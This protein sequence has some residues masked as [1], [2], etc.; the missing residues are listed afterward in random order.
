[1]PVR[2][3]LLVS[4]LSLLLAGGLTRSS[5]AALYDVSVRATDVSFSPPE[6][7]LGTQT[8][9]YATITNEGER[10]VEGTV[11][12]YDNDVLIGS[13]LFS[14]RA[15]V[16]PEDAW[17][18]WTPQGYGAHNI[19][20]QVENDDAFLDAVPGNNRV[21]IETFIDR[22][23]DGDGVPDQADDDRD[24]DG[25]LNTDEVT[26]GTDPLRRDTDG[27]GVD[28][29]RDLFPLD[30]RRSALPP[31]TPTSTRRTTPV[32]TPTAP[33]VTTPAVSV[34]RAAAVTAPVAATSVEQIASTTGEVVPLIETIPPPPTEVVQESE[35][36]NQAPPVQV[37]APEND[38]WRA[39]LILAALLSA[40][41][42]GGFIWLSR[43]E[44]EE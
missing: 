12:F 32:T 27:D 35:L 22:D 21:T 15:H 33:R 39:Y 34:P 23:T 18:R 13:K 28:D 31:P 40:V 2:R 16:R 14:V 41:V 6:L 37:E 11:R 8:R 42:A 9:I 10:D 1:M 26:R 5:A 19:R 25:I 3:I 17:V 30:A 38:S 44:R 43:R 4:G 29:R 20:I 24:S 36:T 7:I